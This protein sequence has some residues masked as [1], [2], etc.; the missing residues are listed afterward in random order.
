MKDLVMNKKCREIDRLLIEYH[1]EVLSPDR[2]KQVEEHL[3][4]CHGCRIKLEEIQNAFTLLTE[5]EVPQPQESFW[6]DFL[7]QVRSRIEAKDKTRT[8]F[9]PN[10][11]WA[12]G[13]TS[14]LLVMIVGSLLFT[15]DNQTVV[16][17]ETEQPLETTLAL[18]NPYTYADQLAEI[19]TAQETEPVAVEALLSNGGTN[20]L[21]LAAEVLDED[22]LNQVDINS[23]LGEL[24]LE[25]LRQ[26]E[27]NVK[28]LN[29]ADIL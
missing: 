1:E 9:R 24:S 7:P 13:L 21:G 26:L 4:D 20:Q 22:Y 5:D 14:V 23:I 17:Q 18:S 28:A 2:K 12:V 3:A 11:R 29:V 15:K 8:I 27:D 16:Q 6:I 10:V 25:E 19:L